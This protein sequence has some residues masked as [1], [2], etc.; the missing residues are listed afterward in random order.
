MTHLSVPFAE[1]RFFETIVH[2]LGGIVW[3]AHPETFQFTF[4]SA[5]A[6]RVLGYP[7][8]Q[9]LED[10]AF[11]RAH[12]HPDDVERC[13]AYCRDATQAGR[14]HTFEY[15][16]LAADGRIVWL[17][18]VVTVLT[19]AAAATQLVGIML[20]ITEQ[21]QR[22]AEQRDRDELYRVL[23]DNTSDVITL[24]DLGATR[25]YAS[26]SFA[27]TFGCVPDA[28]FDGVHAEDLA[29]VRR[30]FHNALENG[31]TSSVAFRH[32]HG[33]GSWRWAEARGSRVEYHGEPH[34][35]AVT[36]DITE[37]R[38]LEEQLRQAQKLEAIGLLAGGVAHDFNNLLTVIL[39]YA[40][41]LAELVKDSKTH[42][43]AAEI[44]H[45]CDRAVVLTQQLLAFSRK[46]VLHP[47]VIDLNAV[48]RDLMNML[49]RIIGETI[50]L[51]VTTSGAV[52][53]V[54]AD[55]GQVQQVVTNLAVNARDAMPAG[56]RITIETSS[57]RVSTPD[58]RGELP[59]GHYAVVT[60]SDTGTG[61]P[62][63]ILAR[64]FEPFFT[65]KEPGKGTGLG[66]STVYGIMKQSGGHIEARSEPGAGTVFT[67]YFP[68]TAIPR[69]VASATEKG[70]ADEGH[71]LVLLVEDEDQV[72]SLVGRALEKGGYRVKPASSGTEALE[73]ARAIREPIALLVTD[74]VMP[75]MS[76]PELVRRLEQTCPDLKVL[77][78]SGY[79]G[80]SLLR[81]GVSETGFGFLQKPFTAK[82]LLRKVRQ[83]I[84]EPRGA[85]RAGDAS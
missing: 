44:R 57:L 59:A 66:L 1:G 80:D 61:V 83:L 18:D 13:T 33:D 60:V 32:R 68:E 23:A 15:R 38:R 64:I 67:L 43:V 76:G 2:S 30:E 85:S 69:V 17:R 84:D 75:G 25:V 28:A 77:Y 62:P 5:Q 50:E 52:P 36:R 31:T 9:W 46:Q 22:E 19:D 49:G 40:E 4:V 39:G 37:R 56:G 70:S 51:K 34:I 12:T 6:E 71:E 42:V 54:L 58:G 11:W 45:A 74:V 29:I 21:K 7:V 8:S 78:I 20:D 72:R 16:M 63:E 41:L 27:R 53:P 82:V 81:D 14:D 79:A 3:A 24:Y 65:T 10:P 47:T 26:P 55:A 48:I 73:I 35:L